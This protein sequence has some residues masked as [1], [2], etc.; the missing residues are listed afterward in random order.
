MEL[1]RKSQE[2]VDRTNVETGQRNM[3]KEVLFIDGE[4]GEKRW[5]G[6]SGG[7]TVGRN[8]LTA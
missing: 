5:N 1:I 6:E 4:V 2:S 3:Q 8:R 7:N